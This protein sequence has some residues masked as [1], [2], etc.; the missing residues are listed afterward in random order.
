VHYDFKC[1]S[2]RH[3]TLCFVVEGGYSDN[4]QV[5][6]FE[7]EQVV[8]RCGSEDLTNSC[9]SIACSCIAFFWT[10]CLCLGTLLHHHH[11]RQTKPSH[12]F[13]LYFVATRKLSCSIVASIGRKQ[14]FVFQR[15]QIH[16]HINKSFRIFLSDSTLF[17]CCWNLQSVNI[18][19]LHL[20]KK[21]KL[22]LLFCTPLLQS[23][24]TQ[25]TLQCNRNHHPSDFI[26]SVPSD[27]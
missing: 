16:T 9:Y 25:I 5:R 8:C 15:L 12:Y 10:S 21:I 13:L 26:C 22:F 3:W 2:V 24:Q 19:T 7:Q 4:N 20:K 14:R 6:S 17:P 1:S 18:L 27:I 11:H 23:L